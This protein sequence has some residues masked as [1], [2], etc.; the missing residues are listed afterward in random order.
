MDKFT[1]ASFL[2]CVQRQLPPEARSKRTA[3]G[4]LKTKFLS[5]R[6]RGFPNGGRGLGRQT[7]RV[8]AAEYSKVVT[9]ASCHNNLL[10]QR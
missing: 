10:K 6:S 8:L 3:L 4:V 9:A 1:K 7:V 2:I 5:F